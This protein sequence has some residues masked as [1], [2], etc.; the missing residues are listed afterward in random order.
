MELMTV[1]M[2]VFIVLLC[3]PIFY[4]TFFFLRQLNRQLAS[5]LKQK[6]RMRNAR[7]ETRPVYHDGRPRRGR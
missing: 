3:F 7:N 4:L 5:N 2:I 6:Q 1:L